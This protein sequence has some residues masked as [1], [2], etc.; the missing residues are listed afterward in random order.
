MSAQASFLR[1]READ[2]SGLEEA[3]SHART[4]RDAVDA[5]LQVHAT[6]VV[7]FEASGNIFGT[8]FVYLMQERSMDLMSSPY[9]GLMRQ[10]AQVLR[11]TWV[12]FTNDHRLRYLDSL[13]AHDFDVA[14]LG[15]FYDSFT[16]T[17]SPGAGEAMLR[18]ITTLAAAV[19]AVEAG[20]VVVLV[21]D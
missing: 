4:D 20:S 15:A 2:L 11:T 3:L 7:T 13:N 17:A 6:P 8:L 12:F 16:Q 1:I 18:A 21:G 10:A 5:Y 9:T 19:R 14:D